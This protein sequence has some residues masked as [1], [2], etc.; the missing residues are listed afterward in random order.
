LK[1]VSIQRSHVLFCVG[2]LAK[3]KESEHKCHHFS[4]KLESRFGRS[5]NLH[6]TL[7]LFALLSEIRIPYIIVNSDEEKQQLFVE[8]R[9]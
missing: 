5:E 1:R 7:S 4:Q 3:I 9:I 8:K 2:D 6:G